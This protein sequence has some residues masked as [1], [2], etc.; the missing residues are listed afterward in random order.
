MT[1]TPLTSAQSELAAKYIPLAKR[2]ARRFRS[3]FPRER[4]DFRSAA[5]YGLC[6]AAG[7]FDPAVGINFG[8]WAPYWINGAML[9][10]RTKCRKQPPH[11]MLGEVLDPSRPVAARDDDRDQVLDLIRRLPG[12]HRHLCRLLYLDGLDRREAG[13]VMGLSKSRVSTLHDEAMALLK[14]AA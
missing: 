12:K 6:L 13:R 5:F 4:P 2:M 8:R 14:G 3:V 10:H 11:D 1:P 9:N 7:T